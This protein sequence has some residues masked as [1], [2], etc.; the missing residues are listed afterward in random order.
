MELSAPNKLPAGQIP[1]EYLE[2][3]LCLPIKDLCTCLFL[4]GPQMERRRDKGL[5]G[6]GKGCRGRRL[7]A[8]LSLLMTVF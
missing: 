7:Q 4:V 6:W 1:L 8:G 3:H 5:G 2:T